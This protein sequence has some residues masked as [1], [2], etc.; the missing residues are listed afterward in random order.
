MS[1]FFSALSLLFA[2]AQAAEH[3]LD[4]EA[5]WLHS[6]DQ[7][8][9]TFSESELYGTLGLRIG[10]AFHPRLAAI[11]G[12]QHGNTGAELGAGD[13]DEYDALT[14]SYPNPLT[15]AFYGDQVTAGIK[16]DVQLA[17]WFHPYATLQAAAMHGVA[18]FDD[19]PD[20]DD[21][22]TQVQGGGWTGGGLVA[23]GA[24]FPIPLGNSGLS[25]APYTELGYGLYAPLKLGDFGSVDLRGFTGRAGI[26][27]RF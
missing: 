22:L 6:P 12:W 11:V 9:D 5:G 1:P 10:Y 23:A 13:D 8:W 21:N 4:V 16:G 26:G 2:T 17:E 3:E 14:A 19:D 25:L 15:A 24:E 27:L 20:R 18:R 7:A